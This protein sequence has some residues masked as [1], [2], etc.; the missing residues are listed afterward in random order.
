MRTDANHALG[1][2]AVGKKG[3]KTAAGKRKDKLDIGYDVMEA[4]KAIKANRK[5]SQERHLR[6]VSPLDEA[7]EV[8]AKEKGV[9]NQTV[10]DAYDE[11]N[12]LVRTKYK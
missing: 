5:I 10:R 8:I 9:S 12:K 4:H 3:M 11:W 1:I 6:G 7:I 2:T